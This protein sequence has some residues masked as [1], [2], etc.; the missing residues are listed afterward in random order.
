MSCVVT[1]EEAVRKIPDGATVLVN[2]VPSEE[3]FGA[4]SRVYEAAGSPRDLTIV[5]AAGLGPFSAERRGMNHFAYPGMTKRVIAGHV[6]LNY[7][8]VKLIATNQ[9]EAYNLP[10]GVMTQLYREIAAKRPGLV[11][12]IGL[13]TFVDPR[14]EGGKLNERT[15]PCEDLV[16]VVEI[17]GREYLFYKSFPV[18]AGLVR[19][20][21]ADPK[22]NITGE[23]EAIPMENLEV[24]MAARN[25]GGIVIAQVERISDKPAHP[26]RVT[27]PGLFVDYV[28]V[29]QSRKN[30]PHTLFVEHDPSYTGEVQ[31]SLNGELH[32]LPLNLGKVIARRAALELRAGMIVNLGVGIPMCVAAVAFE[33][34]LLDAITMNTEVGI[35]GGLPQGGVNFG[36]A[37]NP[38]AFVSQA[39]MFDFYDGGG[40]DQTC[41][42]LAQVDAAGNVNVS[43]LG[44]KI[45]GAG[46]FIDITQ[47]ARSCCF[48]GEFTAGGLKASVENGRLIVH[49]DGQVAKFVGHVQQTTF[50]GAIAR[51]KDQAV[52]YVTERCVFLL[53]S[54]GLLLKE[55]A[56]GIRLQEDVLDKMRFR[57][58]VPDELPL[59]DPRIFQDKPMGI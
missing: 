52:L 42:G 51:Q 8:L 50:S 10:Q 3:V 21:T 37:K 6:G 26:K 45:I 20:T 47:S 18:N 34:K 13:G 40:L 36:P 5:Y 16:Q 46:G 59:M 29:A 49:E 1:A 54:E 39:Q 53:V 32:T 22:G 23:D 35:F 55:I 12:P 57:P 28:V 48:C 19:G 11:T 4:F 58:I 27:V 15:Q 44:P 14:F 31:T 41:V 2:P 38:S 33:E 17:N 56:P 30:H 43:K 25:S 24:A 9:I 7:V